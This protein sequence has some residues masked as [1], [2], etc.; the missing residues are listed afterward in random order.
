MVT[1]ERELSVDS[2][3]KAMDQPCFQMVSLVL[4]VQNTGIPLPWILYFIFQLSMVTIM[5]L[6]VVLFEINGTA[7]PFNVIITYSQLSVNGIK[8][9]SGL[10]VASACNLS[11]KFPQ[12]FLT[13]FGIWNLDFFRLVLPPV[14][15]STF[16]K[17]IDI[18]LFDY[19]IAFFHC[20]SP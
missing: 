3:L 10:Y 13:L 4:I 5:Y 16:I 6:A 15:V 20:L 9:G 18:L 14:C 11:R 19:I 1:T 12:Y 7:S 17:A 8:V 2:A